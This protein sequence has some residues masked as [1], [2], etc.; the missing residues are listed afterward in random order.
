[1]SSST[2]GRRSPWTIIG[3]IVAVLVL[4]AAA[5]FAW[6]PW[7]GTST[8]DTA[9]SSSQQAEDA[10]GTADGSAAD[11]SADAAGAADPVIVAA[12]PQISPWQPSDKAPTAA[13]VAARLAD[14]LAN[15]DI[16]R[17]SGIV[18]DPETGE[19]LWE[20][21]ADS[22]RVPASSMKVLTAATLLSSV[23]PTDRL[24]TK[25]VRG[26]EPGQIVFVGGGDVTL[27]A[28]PDGAPTVL[29]GGPT[30]ADLAD[31]ITAAGVEVTSI[32]LDTSHW[33]GPEMAE[34]WHEDEVTGTPQVA[35]GFVTPMQALMVDADRVD[36]NSDNS[37]RT[38][39]PAMTAGMALARA[40]GDESIPISSGTAPE[41]AEVVA[42]VES[43]PFATLIAQ[44]LERSDNVLSE[45]LAREAALDRGLPGSFDGFGFA[46]RDTLE[47]LDID[48]AGVVVKDGS[49]MSNGNRVPIRVL[50]QVMTHVV[51]G[52]PPEQSV[53]LAGLPLAGVSGT[54]AEN[55]RFTQ[56]E[57]E[58]GRGWVRAKTGSLDDTYALVGY[59]PDVDGR[60][61][62]FGFNSNAVIGNPTRWAQDALAA[63]LRGCGCSDTE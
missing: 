51:A 50:A 15:P 10:T 44:S 54:L 25:V 14:G 37:I 5:M 39:T 33:S 16:A 62:V 59:V 21:N 42:Q 43:Q 22:A 40:L 6:R 26:S 17:L 11:L 28:R 23:N 35:Q 45:A 32:V 31:Q 4:V 49:G 48:T 38:G 27:S 30:I 20:L 53:M 8:T 34:G 24:V 1:M 29:P 55:D 60:L 57:T 13:G 18:I 46:V 36:P 19:V 56:P 61:L 9:L 58:A 52:D 41:G 12:Q 3:A 47:S 7:S 2:T 63:A